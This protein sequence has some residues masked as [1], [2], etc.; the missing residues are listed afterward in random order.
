MKQSIALTY[1]KD[2]TLYLAIERHDDPPTDIHKST[3]LSRVQRSLAVIDLLCI[4]TG[5]TQ[6]V[7][8][9]AAVTT[10]VKCTYTTSPATSN[11]MIVKGV[12]IDRNESS[13]VAILIADGQIRQIGDIEEIQANAPR[14]RLLDCDGVY[15]SP[16]FVNP[17]EH[18][19]YSAG[20]PGPNV[21]PVYKNRYQW[22]GRGGEQYPE[23]AYS[24]VETDAQLYWIE[25]R[26]L[27]SG[28]TTMAG[29]GAVPGLLK[30]VGSGDQESGFV[31]QAD[32]KT[33]PF[34]Q[35]IDEFEQLTW[36]YKGPSVKPELTEGADLRSPF[37]PHIAEGIDKIS[38]LEA[39]FFLDYVAANPGRRYAMIHGVGLHRDSASR[40]QSLDVTLV[41]APRSNLA[42]YGVTVDVPHLIDSGARVALS[43]DWSYSGSYNMLES[44]RCAKHINKERWGNQLSGRDLWLMATANAAYALNLEHTTGSVKPGLAA[45]LVLVNAKSDN[46]YADLM[47]SQVADIVATLVDGELVAG[48]R[49]AFD[50][51]ELPPTCSNFVGDHFVCDDLSQRDFSWPQLLDMN[52]AAVPLFEPQGQASCTL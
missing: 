22:Q 21:A 14:A 40:L 49:I 34:P 4:S 32:M 46:L 33:F 30:N 28:T 47:E 8:A 51:V 18:P 50:T 39:K 2:T 44:F 3:F 15:I 38:R 45:D 26:H 20:K 35:A 41:W 25:L 31:Y 19:P 27:L 37:V 36:P 16:G 23:I 6:Y 13:K 29:N 9:E 11:E 10:T 52:E 7:A 42:L 48:S 17:H 1:E 12:L 43:T 24:R 5:V